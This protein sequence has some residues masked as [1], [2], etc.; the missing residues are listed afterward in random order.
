VIISK[1]LLYSNKQQSR[2]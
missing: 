1:R 2:K